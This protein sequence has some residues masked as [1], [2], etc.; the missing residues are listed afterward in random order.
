MKY[1]S[2][3]KMKFIVKGI[4]LEK[5]VWSDLPDTGRQ[6]LYVFTYRCTLVLTSIIS[7]LYFIESQR[8]VIK[9]GT[10]KC[11]ELLMLHYGYWQ[12]YLLWARTRN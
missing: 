2:A 8:I 1:Y 9:K 5:S 7:N 3:A 12:E 10:R 4:E 11:E 6:I